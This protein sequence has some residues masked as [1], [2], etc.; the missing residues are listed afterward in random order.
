[1]NSY[2]I[3]RNETRKMTAL[4]AMPNGQVVWAQPEP[5]QGDRNPAHAETGIVGWKQAGLIALALVSPLV[6]LALRVIAF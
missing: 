4:M 1:M 2:D 6:L 5:Y 3:N